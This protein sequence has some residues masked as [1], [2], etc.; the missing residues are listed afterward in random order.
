MT[1]LMV[2]TNLEVLFYFFPTLH[3]SLYVATG[4]PY[5]YSRTLVAKEYFCLLRLKIIR[6]VG[7]GG[8]AL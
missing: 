6:P 1:Y 8:S 4:W 2:L 7:F 5:E 3:M